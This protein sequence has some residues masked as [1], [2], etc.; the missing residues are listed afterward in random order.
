[1]PSRIGE[2]AY[3]LQ[4]EY[5]M[6]RKAVLTITIIVFFSLQC[7]LFK[8]L[9]L[10]S[11]SPNLL[12]ILTFAAGFMRGKKEGMYVGLFSGFILDVFFGKQLGFYSLLYMYIGYI[13]GIFNRVFYDEDVTLPIG[14]ICASDF[15]YNFVFYIFSFLIRNRLHLGY[16]FVHI[17][18]PEMLYTVIVMLILYRP[19]LWVNHKIEN[20]EKRGASR[21][22]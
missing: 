10:A 3:I 13:N 15:L 16:Y 21:F 2:R 12:L 20:K 18:F 11:V 19:M 5:R 7:T 1:M 4:E 9:S 6:L 22:D 8:V 14:L 17:M